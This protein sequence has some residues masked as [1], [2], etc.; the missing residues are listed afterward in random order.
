MLIRRSLIALPLVAACALPAVAPAKNR[1]ARFLATFDG[2]VH[3]T[4]NYPK[5]QWAKDCYRTQF[6]EGHGEQTWHVHT[7]GPQKILM[8]SNGTTTQFLW[9][10][11]DATGTDGNDQTGLLAK[12]EV[13]RTH[14][15][16]V[17]FGAG[18][19]GVTQPYPIEPEP[20]D[21]GTRLVNYEV[22][23]SGI[24][25]AVDITPD[26]LT[27]GQNGIREKTGFEHCSLPAVENVPADMWPAASGR[28][29]AK[30]KPVKGWF[31]KHDTLTATGKDR[32]TGKQAVGGG[33]RTAE[34]TIEWTLKFTRVPDPTKATNKKGGRKHRR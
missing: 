9:G 20:N 22:I 28:L 12:G 32:W 19:C 1:Q 23:L 21:C 18:S 27:D 15:D 31:G 10:G 11:W 3:N 30:G 7:A 13:T 29:M 6:Y 5:T 25:R 14:T 33:D 24:G 8:I 34:T 17:T 16:T 2:T 26:V 4:W